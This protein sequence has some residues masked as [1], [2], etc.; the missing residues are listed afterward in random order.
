[1]RGGDAG[2]GG[3][4]TTDAPVDERG[5]SS[6]AIEELN[7]VGGSGE[8]PCRAEKRFAVDIFSAGPT[9]FS[10]AEDTRSSYVHASC[11]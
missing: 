11:I 10:A 4:E 2:V 6:D 5:R 9:R 1:M 3:K 8:W 7:R